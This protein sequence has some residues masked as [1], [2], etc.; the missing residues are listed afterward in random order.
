MMET[1]F[2]KPALLSLNPQ[3]RQMITTTDHTSGKR[4]FDSTG[5][6]LRDVAQFLWCDIQRQVRVCHLQ[7]KRMP[8]LLL[9]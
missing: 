9:H 2:R 4:G 5:A 8:L 3:V 6:K 1:L 7:G